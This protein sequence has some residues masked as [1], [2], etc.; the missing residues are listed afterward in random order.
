MAAVWHGAGESKSRFAIGL[1]Q[2]AFANTGLTAPAKS[3]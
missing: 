1:V 3:A 2:G